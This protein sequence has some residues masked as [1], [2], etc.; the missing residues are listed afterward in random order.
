MRSVNISKE[1]AHR[2]DVAIDAVQK[3]SSRHL[4][5][6][7]DRSQRPCPDAYSGWNGQYFY[8]FTA[9]VEV[10]REEV[11]ELVAA[12]SEAWTDLGLSLEV[13][14][15]EGDPGP[16]LNARQGDEFV[17]LSYLLPREDRSLQVVIGTTTECFDADDS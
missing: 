14:R 6:E 15:W 10:A 5:V 11:Q 13:R 2:L 9:S 17:Q 3:A 1:A 4:T 8:E 12:V 7:K 16:T